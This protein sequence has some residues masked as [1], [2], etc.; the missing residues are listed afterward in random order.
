MMR[1][2]QY[3]TRNTQYEKDADRIDLLRSRVELLKGK[4]RTLMNMYLERDGSFREMARMAGV[5]EATIARR[6]YKLIQRLIDGEYITCLRNRKKFTSL[7]M[8]IARDYFLSGLSMRK[9]AA[10]RDCSYYQV[11]QC[12][13]KIQWLVQIKKEETNG[14]GND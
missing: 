9:I 12:L 2:T 13:K 4:D 10:K 3:T 1:N 7:E 5:N 6:I 8:F 11:R 14:D